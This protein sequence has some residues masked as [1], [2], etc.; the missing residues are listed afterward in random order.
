MSEHGELRGVLEALLFAS[1]EPLPASRV[2]KL[3]ELTDRGV[4]EGTTQLSEEYAHEERGVQLGG[5]PRD[6]EVYVR[7]GFH[8]ARDA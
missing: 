8:S 1:D 6:G 3:L 4:T 2:A 7:T 5:A